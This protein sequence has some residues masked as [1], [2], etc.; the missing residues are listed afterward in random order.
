M[1][2]LRRLG[3]RKVGVALRVLIVRKTP[4]RT[5]LIDAYVSEQS[6]SQSF[7]VGRALQSML[8]C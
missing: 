5:Y 2:G 7:D 8:L 1:K 6:G 3:E 4:M